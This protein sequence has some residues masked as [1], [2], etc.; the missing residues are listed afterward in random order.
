M[1]APRILIVDDDAVIG[2]LM[3][4]ILETEGFV[5][6][7]VETTEPGAVSA[8]MRERP[9]LVIIDQVLGTGSGVRAIEEIVRDSPVPYVLISGMVGARTRKVLLKPFRKV[10]LLQAMAQALAS[11]TPA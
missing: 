10:D 8:A 4:E 9:D 2:M 11:A 3:A 7:G 6:C 1:K 5:I